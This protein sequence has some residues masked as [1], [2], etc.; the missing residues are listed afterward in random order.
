MWGN[1]VA[2][3][4]LTVTPTQTG[5]PAS[6][7]SPVPTPASG[8]LPPSDLYVFSPSFQD[9]MV[10]Q[11]FAT[12]KR[13][14]VRDGALSVS[15]FGNSAVNLPFSI[16]SNP[17]IIGTAPNGG[18]LYGG[19]SDRPNPSFGNIYTTGSTGYQHFNGFVACI[20][21]ARSARPQL[22]DV[23]QLAACLRPGVCQQ[24]PSFWC[25]DDATRPCQSRSWR[26]PWGLQPAQ[27]LHLH[28]CLNTMFPVG[29]T[30]V[31]RFLNGWTLSA[32]TVAPS[33]LPSSPV[34]GRDNN[35]DLI[36][37]DRP[38]GFGYNSYRLPAYVEA[39][40]RVSRDIHIHDRNTFQMA[41]EIFNA[42]NHL[43]VT[44]VTRTPLHTEVS[45]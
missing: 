45:N 14:L 23:V 38:V 7:T 39:D 10:H 27:S 37:N 29:D 5:V 30:T 13:Q 17:A 33:G 9:P 21:A 19:T 31:A 32:R 34:T 36:F 20:H 25:L 22:P 24:L 44:N 11:F 8:A 15:Y 1:G 26:R 35:G 12:L 18:P 4:N 16:P 3:R 41:G 6:T 40:F 42:P 43:N 2:V 28:R